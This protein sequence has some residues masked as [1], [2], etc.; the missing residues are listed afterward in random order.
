MDAESEAA[1]QSQPDAAVSTSALETL[2]FIFS[3]L[4]FEN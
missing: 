2:N 3:A 4:N 1:M